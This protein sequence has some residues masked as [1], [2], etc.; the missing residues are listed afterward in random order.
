VRVAI[1]FLLLRDRRVPRLEDL[2]QNPAGSDNYVLYAGVPR[3]VRTAEGQSRSWRRPA[4]RPGDQLDVDGRYARVEFRIND[5]ITVFSSA[6]VIKKAT[7]LLGDNYL[8]IDPGEPIKQAP[9]GTEQKFAQLGPTCPTYNDKDPKKAEPCRK[10]PN[11]VEATTPESAA[12]PDRADAAERRS[13]ARERARSIGGRA[14]DR[15]RPAVQR[16]D[17]HRRARPARGRHGAGHHR[18]RGSIR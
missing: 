10:I 4:R 1:L 6:V 2:G 14:P 3:R 9:D 16:R 8:E 17:A 15:E 12:A 7:S 18:A 5:E 13:R 11:V